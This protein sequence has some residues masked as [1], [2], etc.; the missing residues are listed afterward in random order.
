MTSPATEA[1]S[2]R[3]LT[4]WDEMSL[5]DEQSAQT[6]ESEPDTLE[7]R[8]DSMVIL[9]GAMS[10]LRRPLLIAGALVGTAVLL[11]VIIGALVRIAKGDAPRQPR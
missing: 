11:A 9:E 6:P 7:V 8:D 5:T 1:G 4:E 10:S 2:H 3:H